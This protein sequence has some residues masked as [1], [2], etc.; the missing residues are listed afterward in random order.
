MVFR[1]F[2]A[3]CCEAR[4]DSLKQFR[5]CKPMSGASSQ[6]LAGVDWHVSI[7]PAQVG[8]RALAATLRAVFRSARQLLATLRKSQ[9]SGPRSALFGMTFLH[10]MFQAPSLESVCNP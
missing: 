7:G 1:P 9:N 2:W 4:L 10:S 8:F 6:D 5:S 3:P